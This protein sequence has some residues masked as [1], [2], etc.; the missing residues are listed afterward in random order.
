MQLENSFDVPAP[1]DRS[2]R[3]LNDVPAVVPCMP[4]AEL[5]EV[6]SDDA[7]RARIDVKLGPISLQFLA[8]VVR[9]AIDEAAGRVVLAVNAREAKGRGS[10]QATIESTISPTDAG[11]TVRLVTELE[12]RGAVAQYGR[13][14]VADVAATLTRQFADCLARTLSEKEAEAPPPEPAAA[15]GGLGLLLGA[16]WRA[17]TRRR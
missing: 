13:G 6:V 17:L 14:V 11:S 2:W 15:V 1:V 9:E 7:W 8:D 4:G 12:L 10:S 16:F 3:L 5:L